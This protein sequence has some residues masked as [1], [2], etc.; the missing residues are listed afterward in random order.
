MRFLRPH[1]DDVFIAVAAFLGGVL[2]WSLGLYSHPM[3]PLPAWAA[4]VPLAVICAAELFRRSLP[5]V[6]LLVGTVALIADLFT[7]G[8]LATILVFTDVVYAAVVYGPPRIARRIPVVSVP[9]TVASTIAL[10]LW[11]RS[12]QGL[13]LGVVIG[14]ITIA[15]AMTGVII[16]NHREAADVARLRAEQT[17]LLA[18]MDQAQAVAAERGRMARELHDMVANHLSAIAIHS[19][20]ALS[21]D[22]PATTRQ[23]LGTIRENSVA[24]LADMRRMIGLLREGDDDR[25]P[26]AVP[27]L[28]GLET[29]AEKARTDGAPSGL[30]FTLDDRRNEKPPL[31]A[32]V[33][34]AAYRLVQESLT[35]ALKHA[36]AGEVRIQ[37]S[38]DTDGTLT[39]AVTSPYLSRSHPRAPGS[40]SG[41]IGIRERVGLVKGEVEAGPAPGPPGGPPDVWRVRAVLPVHHDQESS[42]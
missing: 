33:E 36:G 30:T 22:D 27:T 2:L 7:V 1:R 4:L 40:G 11:T 32:P 20:A 25:S 28:A 8:N 29:L 12:P 19:T 5:P 14:M 6:A 24:A 31:P 21:L 15:P 37:L 3:S 10:L 13:L 35:N 34:L 42:A 38:Q 18:E 17:T 9:L 26:A 23:S 16:R 39:V 41:L